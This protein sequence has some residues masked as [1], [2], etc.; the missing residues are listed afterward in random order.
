MHITSLQGGGSTA[1]KGNEDMSK[2]IFKLADFLI[3]FFLIAHVKLYIAQS[4]TSLS[5]FLSAV[6]PT[7]TLQFP[8]VPSSVSRAP[9]TSVSL[10]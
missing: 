7:S 10:T 8:P 6:T 5:S 1:I 2:S 4:T 3:L 9:M